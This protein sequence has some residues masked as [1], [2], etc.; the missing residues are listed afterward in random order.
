M[1]TATTR[2]Y[3]CL[4][5]LDPAKLA[6]MPA[7]ELSDLNA[8]H[9]DYNDR[10]RASGHLIAAEALAPAAA[11]ATVRVRH[12]VPSVTDGPF[13]EAKEVVAGFYLIEAR[14]AEEAAAIASRIPSAS[15]ATVEIREAT[16]LV[17]DGR[18]P[19]WG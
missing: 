12:G 13:A 7:R 19:R 6:A 5:H 18:E 1:T 9:L 4:I 8:A 11:A 16:Q 15:F 2:R 14:D 3:L 17:V 10:L